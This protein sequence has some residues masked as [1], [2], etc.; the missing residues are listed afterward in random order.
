M[1][2]KAKEVNV[3]VILGLTAG[4]ATHMLEVGQNFN[5]MFYKLPC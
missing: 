2:K 4:M 1:E 5:P 3:L